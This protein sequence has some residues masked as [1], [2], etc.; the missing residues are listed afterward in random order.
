MNGH[1]KEPVAAKTGFWV[2]GRACAANGEAEANDN[3]PTNAICRITTNA[4][5]HHFKPNAGRRDASTPRHT[6]PVGFADKRQA[7]AFIQS[8]TFACWSRILYWILIC[9]VDSPVKAKLKNQ[10]RK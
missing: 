2:I 10:G 1:A 8:G 7:G 5:L 3:K 9:L 6:I 4:K